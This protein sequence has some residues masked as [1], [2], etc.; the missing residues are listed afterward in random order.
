MSK[1]IEAVNN[2]L[3]CP[4]SKRQKNKTLARYMAYLTQ[5]MTQ[6]VETKGGEL[7]VLAS[8][9]SFVASAA[10]NFHTDEPETL[11]WIEKYIEEGDVLWDIGAN[12]GLYSMYAAQAS[13]AKVYAFEPAG[14]NYGILVEHI[15]INKLDQNIYPLSIALGE[16]TKLDVLHMRGFE[17]GIALNSIGASKNQ[18]GE[19]DSVMAQGT[20]QMKPEDLCSIFGVQKPDHIK[21]DVDSIEEIIVRALQPVLVDAKTIT[22][23]VEGENAKDDGAEIARMITECGFEEVKEHREKGYRR[24]RLWVKKP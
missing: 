15:F 21:L 18:F 2:V 22:V 4:L 19:F 8:R 12:I 14:I 10:E 17:A 6:K 5:N 3:L 1:V 24:N 23:E 7:K 16:E 11:E 9:G 20:L 13:K